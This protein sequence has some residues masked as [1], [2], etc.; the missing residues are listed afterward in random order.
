M[1]FSGTEI[2]IVDLVALLIVLLSLI[3][4]IR[5]GFISG[6]LDLF[7]LFVG[8]YLA[9]K[10]YGPIGDRI[11]D[12]FPLPRG[13]ANLAAFTGIF[14]LCQILFSL[15]FGFVSRGIR[16]LLRLFLPLRLINA[17]A[18]I[19]PG[20]IKGIIG[21]TLLML[22][23]GLFPII[24]GAKDQIEKSYFGSRVISVASD[25]A[26]RLE[27]VLGQTADETLAFF[28]RSQPG[29]PLNL[30]FPSAS[31]LSVDA[32]SESRMLEMVNSERA[33]AG[34]SPLV[35]DEKLRAAARDHSQEMFELSYFAHESPVNGTPADRIRAAGAKFMMAAEN[36]AYAPNVEMAH[37]GLM[38]SPG[39][40]QNILTP[41]FRRIGIGV[42]DGGI[43][44][45]MFTQNFTD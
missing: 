6:F 25:V 11:I 29:K 2:N 33:K 14:I 22:P 20:A 8:I 5:N 27:S 12:I 32:S 21:V 7:G 38:N 13:I 23:F 30:D 31:S 9:F 28:S 24:P 42:I 17:A 4:G 19:L 39:H 3:S 34:L 16:P 15:A 26:P 44:G 36:L 10:G 35:L 41:G 43:K 37:S 18:G 1:G 45:K 40:R